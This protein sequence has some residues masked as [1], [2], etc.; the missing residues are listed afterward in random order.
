MS[1]VNQ[2]KQ[3]AM[4][5]KTAATKK[6]ARG[7]AVKSARTTGIMPQIKGQPMDPLEKARRNNGIPGFKAGGKVKPCGCK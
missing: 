3:M 1:L 2:H 5:T 4:G 6:M 7:G